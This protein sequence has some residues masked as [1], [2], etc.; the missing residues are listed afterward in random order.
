MF[1]IL[2]IAVIVLLKS[3][4]HQTKTF[5]HYYLNLERLPTAQYTSHFGVQH[6]AFNGQLFLSTTKLKRFLL[7]I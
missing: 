3:C 5:D 6:S 4:F 2:F 1:D 7:W